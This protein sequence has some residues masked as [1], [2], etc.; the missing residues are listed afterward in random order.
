MRASLLTLATELPD[1]PPGYPVR[2][3]GHEL[4]LIAVRWLRRS[5]AGRLAG[6][7]SDA[8]LGVLELLQ[9]HTGVLGRLADLC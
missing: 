3:Q 9:V 1:G 2:S 8:R 4:A 5:L 6:E 7:T